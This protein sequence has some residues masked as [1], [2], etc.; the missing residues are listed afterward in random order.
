MSD[1]NDKKKPVN[2]KDLIID[3][4]WNDY[5]NVQHETWKMLYERQIEILEPRICVEYLDGLKLLDIS[6]DKIPDFNEVNERLRAATGWEVV[7]TKGLIK[8]KAFFDML[9]NKKFPSGTF[10]RAREELDY[11]EEP[12]I[13]HDVFG[14]IPLLTNP[15][16]AAYM[17]E[18][19]KGGERALEFKTTKHLARL[20]WWTIEFGLIARDGKA[21]IYGAG[22]A[23]SFGEAKYCLDDPSAHHIHFDL[24][25]CM[26]T[27]V[28]ISDYQASYFVID[29][30]DDLFN[31]AVNTDFSPMYKAFKGLEGYIPVEELLPFELYPGDQVLRKGTLDYIKPK[32]K[33]LEESLSI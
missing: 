16:Y 22:L 25:R 13:F 19:G 9:R 12:D 28:Y 10:I 1:S 23:S 14:H 24:E 29:S 20:N 30:F 4:N 31:Q 33:E 18:Y 7:A 17:Y 2:Y 21:K 15:S 11:L 5:T 27:K 32:R 26:R 8:S 6:P 3:Q